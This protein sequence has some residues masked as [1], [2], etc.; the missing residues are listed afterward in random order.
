MRCKFTG[1]DNYT[2]SIIKFTRADDS[3]DINDIR[4]QVKHESD[5]VKLRGNSIVSK[6]SEMIESI[7]KIGD[8]NSQ[9]GQNSVTSTTLGS[10]VPPPSG[11]AI[12]TS[13]SASTNTNGKQLKIWSL[14]PSITP[15]SEILN[16]RRVFLGYCIYR[17]GILPRTEQN[18]PLSILL[19]LDISQWE[20]EIGARILRNNQ[21]ENKRALNS[22]YEIVVHF[23]LLTP[24]IDWSFEIRSVHRSKTLQ[25]KCRRNVV[26]LLYMTHFLMT[27]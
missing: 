12:I 27:G 21:S 26:S 16:S 20:S 18:F 1:H 13:T 11:Q 14:F 3:P 25:D 5:L 6:S 4:N 8:K 23:S 7:N 2:S 10:L 17:K 22:S 24:R 19:I 9:S 15:S